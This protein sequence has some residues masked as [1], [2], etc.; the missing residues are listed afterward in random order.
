MDSMIFFSIFIK[1]FPP[2]R[3]WTQASLGRVP[4]KADLWLLLRATAFF[5][6]EGFSPLA[7]A[8]RLT[9]KVDL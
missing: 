5:S 9:R 4:L 1:A 2:E 3:G 8:K 7:W 6:I